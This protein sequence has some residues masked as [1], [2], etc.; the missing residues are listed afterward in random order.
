MI[1]VTCAIITDKDKILAVQRGP[2]TDHPFLWE[3]PGGKTG[4]GETDEEAI[5][6]EIREELSVEVEITGRLGTVEQDYGNKQ[7]RLIP[8]VCRI[9]G[10]SL[11]LTE[12]IAF[13]WILPEQTS[14]L[15]WSEADLKLIRENSIFFGQNKKD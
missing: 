3:F 10:G 1:D 7:I 4:K 15:N 11:H 9:C 8:F 5:C 2:E 13:C 6:R 14:L 12:H